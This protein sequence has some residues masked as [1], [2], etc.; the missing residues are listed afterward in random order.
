MRPSGPTAAMADGESATGDSRG[1][2][3]RATTAGAENTHVR[4]RPAGNRTA[5][6][7]TV[8]ARGITPTANQRTRAVRADTA[9]RDGTA[10]H[11]DS[12][13]LARRTTPEVGSARLGTGRKAAEIA[14]ALRSRRAGAPIAAGA[15]AARKAGTERAAAPK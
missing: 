1:K 12:A 2:A 15:R 11:W 5:R 4:R 10:S 3:K 9:D 13:G 14:R 6:P 7:G 8:S